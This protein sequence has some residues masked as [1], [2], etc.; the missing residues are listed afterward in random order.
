[1]ND[2]MLGQKTKGVAYFCPKCTNAVEVS[3]HL[4][5]VGNQIPVHC[6]GCGWSGDQ[7]ELAQASFSHEFKSP[8]EISKAM[9]T[10]LRNALAESSAIVYGRFLLKWGF[11][12][13]PVRGAELG[14]YLMNIANAT[15]QSIIQT[16]SE[17]MKE[18]TSGTVKRG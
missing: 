7:A 15:V 3:T 6:T 11:M 13:E 8:E 12:G 17:L 16:R 2:I 1:M 18:S 10:D 5:L 4:G 14:R 9:V